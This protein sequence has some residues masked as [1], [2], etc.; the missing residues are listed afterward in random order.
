MW[1]VGRH[2]QR[3]SQR[4]HPCGGKFKRKPK[5]E[6]QRSR[7]EAAGAEARHVVGS[8]EPPWGVI[9]K[10]LARPAQQSILV[11]MGTLAGR[12]GPVS[13]R[14]GLSELPTG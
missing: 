14:S 5:A 1:R 3:G 11:Y 9:S 8:R 4:T 12:R 10:P 7:Q 2:R 13:G 6:K